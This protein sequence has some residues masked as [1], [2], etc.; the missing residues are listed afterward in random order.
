MPLDPD[1]DPELRR[2]WESL[3]EGSAP[4][5]S[6]PRPL[7]LQEESYPSSPSLQDAASF[8]KRQHERERAHWRELLEVKEQTERELSTRLKAAQEDLAEVKSRSAEAEDELLDQL[9]QATRSLEEVQRELRTTLEKTEG[10]REKEKAALVKSHQDL[11]AKIEAQRDAAEKRWKGEADRCRTVADE[12]SGRAARL[13]AYWKEQEKRWRERESRLASR[14]KELE[15]LSSR[16]ESAGAAAAAEKARLVQFSSE[17]RQA[18]EKALAGLE[19]ERAEREKLQAE[20]DRASEKIRELE[21]RWGELKAQTDA[22]RGQ[23]RDL[24]DRDRQTWEAQRAE[25][26]GWEQRLRQEREA[27]LESLRAKEAEEVETASK[28]AAV[29]R[30]TAEWAAGLAALIRLRPGEAESGGLGPSAGWRRFR[31]LGGF[32]LASAAAAAGLYLFLGTLRVATLGSDVLGLEGATGLAAGTDAVWVS[33]WDGRLLALDPGAVGGAARAF[34]LKSLAPYHPVAVS[35]GALGL[36][37]LDAAQA[38]LLRHDPSEPAKLLASLPAPGAAPAG[39]ADDGQALWTYDAASQRLFRLD[40][41]DG[42][43][44]AYGIE[45]FSPAALAWLDGSLYAYDARASRLARLE[46]QGDHFKAGPRAA[47]GPVVALAGRGRT[48]WS[49][50]TAG[51]AF[52]VGRYKIGW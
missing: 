14:V 46:P 35:A 1:F 19:A 9:T 2:L 11:I 18:L 15:S 20:A 49:L 32:T 31:L 25:F 47:V 40:P 39:L 5:P 41:R 3:S 43:A 22:E 50:E 28:L 21:S 36:W 27:W 6:A 16:L 10:E 34:D 12:A 51:A 4:G 38:R 26:A 33:E 23:W 7:S 29:L 48:L 45:G 44:R 42:T 8:L 37:T 30:Q 17:T 24:W 13:E 52:R